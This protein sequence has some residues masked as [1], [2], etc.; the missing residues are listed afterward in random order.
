MEKATIAFI[1]AFGGNWSDIGGIATLF[2]LSAQIFGAGEAGTLL[3]DLASNPS[4]FNLDAAIDY[5]TDKKKSSK[6]KV[7]RSR[8]TGNN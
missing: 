4:D 1:K 8:I 3:R 6:F 7:W 2:T 5:V